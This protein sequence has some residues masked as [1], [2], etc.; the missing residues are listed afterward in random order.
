MNVVNKNECYQRNPAP[1]EKVA[2]MIKNSSIHCFTNR[3]RAA[4][5]GLW[6][7]PPQHRSTAR[8][9]PANR[10]DRAWRTCSP[11]LTLAGAA[12]PRMSCAMSVRGEGAMGAIGHAPA[13]TV[14][15]VHASGHSQD[16]RTQERS[17]TRWTRNHGRARRCTQTLTLSSQRMRSTAVVKNGASVMSKKKTNKV[18]GAVRTSF[19]SSS[20]GGVK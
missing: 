19:G 7:G 14:V 16:R 4:V 15:F 20:S 17:L 13:T 6:C 8:C 18:R 11:P 3:N 12:T 5:V 1:D 9:H 10:I 2:D